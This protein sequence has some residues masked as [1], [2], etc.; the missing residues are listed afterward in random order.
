MRIL[1]RPRTAK[2]LIWTAVLVFLA[3]LF[4][5]LSPPAA[6][7]SADERTAVTLLTEDG[8]QSLTMAEYLPLAIAAEMPVSFGTEALRAQAVA[9]RSYVLAGPRH[10]EADVCT[11]SGCCLAFQSRDQLRA[12]WGD[13]FDE[14]MAA[15]EAA[16]ADTDGQVLTYDGQIIR[17]V[18]HASSRGATES[19]AAVWAPEPYLVSVESPETPETVPDLTSEAAFTPEELI[20]LLGLEPEGAPETWLGGVARDDAGRAA[21]LAVGGQ[22]LSGGFVRSALGLRSTDFDVTWDGER[23]L[24]TVSGN[25]HGVG[26]SQYGAKLLAGSGLAYDEILAHYYPGT[27]LTSVQAH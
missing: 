8:P 27:E 16:A 5:R 19:S 6:A 15:A 9:V 14:N 25:G 1:Y 3:V 20:R 18:F 4:H 13:D 10:E 7:L 2:V 11:D 12:L 21:S 26:M 23:F 24:F 17:A 22:V